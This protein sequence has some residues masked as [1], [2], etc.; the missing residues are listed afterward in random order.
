MDGLSYR[1]RRDLTLESTKA[2]RT[3]RVWLSDDSDRVPLRV[4]ATT[5]LGEIEMTLS[6]YERP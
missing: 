2:A 1:A 4:T 6:E 3:F 5:E